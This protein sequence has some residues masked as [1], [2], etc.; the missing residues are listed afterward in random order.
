VYEIEWSEEAE[1]D[2]VALAVFKRPAV[3]TAVEELR[4]EAEVE[5]RNRKPLRRVLPR[6]PAAAWNLRV[7]DV[8]VLYRISD[9][10][11][12]QILRVI[13]KGTSTTD[14]ALARSVKP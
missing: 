12:V 3:V 10:P 8:R 4:H 1:A 13:I 6:L 7:A 14:E 5:T 2:L 9:G 11:S